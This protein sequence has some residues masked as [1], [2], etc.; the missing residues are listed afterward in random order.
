VRAWALAVL[1][2]AV[3]F[4]AS[5]GGGGEETTAAPPATTAAAA[6]VPGV[7]ET[8]VGSGQSETVRDQPF[9]L[10]TDQPIPADFEA[11]YQRNSL[12]AVQFYKPVDDPFYPQGLSV[13]TQAKKHLDRLRPDYPTVEFFQ[14]DITQPGTATEQDE[15]REG[16]YGT[17]AAQMGVG[18]TPFVATLAPSDE[19]YVIENLFQ[20]FTPRPVLSQAL[21]DL[22]ATDVNS[23]TSDID[24]T[25]EQLEITDEGGGLEYVTIR[26]RG[27]E[28]VN[29][30]GFGF[31]VLDLETGE[32][33]PD[34]EGLLISSGEDGGGEIQLEAGQ[35]VSIGRAPDVVDQDGERVAGTFAGGEALNL[36]PG[37]QVALLDSGGAVADTFVV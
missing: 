3:V 1:I 32:V 5:C 23:N 30:V 10:N 2:A 37:D 28:P 31:N 19:G 4:L 35:E 21:F 34:T 12:I 33:N 15:L 25:I 13:D 16:E 36:V 11:A 6:S 8:T 7:A 27:A 26:N 20:G 18:L 14:Y 9:Q 17:L 24:V 29:L 22:T